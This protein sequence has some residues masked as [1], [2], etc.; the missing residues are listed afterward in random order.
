MKLVKKSWLLCYMVCVLA[1]LNRGYAGTQ[2]AVEGYMR[3]KKTGEPL[4]GGNVLLV[5]T[6]LGAATDLNGFYNIIN[7]PVG[8]YN[9]RYTYVGYQTVIIKDRLDQSRSQNKT[10]RR[11]CRDTSR[12]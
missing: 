1:F 4:I 5:G 3:D 2:G 10:R 9:V 6:Q 8:T 7:I 12:A 11:S